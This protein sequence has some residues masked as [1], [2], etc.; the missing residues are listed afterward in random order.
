MQMYQYTNNRIAINDD[1]VHTKSQQ[2]NCQVTQVKSINLLPKMI[3]LSTLEQKLSNLS[4]VPIKWQSKNVKY[5]DNNINIMKQDRVPNSVI[6]S[7]IQTAATIL[8][9]NHI[10]TSSNFGTVN[11]HNLWLCG[12]WTS[13]RQP[14]LTCDSLNINNRSINQDESKFCDW[15]YSEYDPIYP[16]QCPQLSAIEPYSF[17]NIAILSNNTNNLNPL[18]NIY[19]V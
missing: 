14:L 3:R 1:C 9:R 12:E 10:R 11:T 17:E 19:I 4:N 13:A 16:S 2:S 6:D 15:N 8:T 7:P 5:K 18:S